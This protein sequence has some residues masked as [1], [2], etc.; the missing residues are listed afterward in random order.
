MQCS[1]GESC[2]YELFAS[3]SP[4]APAVMLQRGQGDVRTKRWNVA[5]LSADS[6]VVLTIGTEPSAARS[7]RL[8]AAVR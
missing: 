1:S 5:A 7:Q 2:E 6:C 8:V 4:G 3:H